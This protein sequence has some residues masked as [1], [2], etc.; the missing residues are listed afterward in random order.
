MLMDMSRDYPS[1]RTLDYA[2]RTEVQG[3][4]WTTRRPSRNNLC[5]RHDVSNLEYYPQGKWCGLGVSHSAHQIETVSR[6]TSTTPKC[7]LLQSQDKLYVASRGSLEQ[8]IYPSPPPLE[9]K[10]LVIIFVVDHDGFPRRRFPFTGYDRVDLPHERGVLV[11]ID[12]C[13]P[14]RQSSRPCCSHTKYIL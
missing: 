13:P 5:A 7:R 3:G 10:F 4:D 14:S 11:V 2:N 8:V 12:G 6:P 1:I 9:P